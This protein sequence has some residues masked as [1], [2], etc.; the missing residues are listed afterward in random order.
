MSVFIVND[1]KASVQALLFVA[2]SRAKAAQ[3]NLKP[4]EKWSNE[5]SKCLGAEP[6]TQ[7]C[8]TY[9]TRGQGGSDSV[10]EE[11]VLEFHVPSAAGVLHLSLS[12]A[13]PR[14]SAADAKA[15]FPSAEAPPIIDPGSAARAEAFS[16]LE[17]LADNLR[18]LR[19]S[20]FM[21]PAFDTRHDELRGLRR[22]AA[23]KLSGLKRLVSG[24]SAAADMKQ[25]EALCTRLRDLDVDL[26]AS[27]EDPDDDENASLLKRDLAEIEQVMEAAGD[28]ASVAADRTA[29]TAIAPPVNGAGEKKRKKTHNLGKKI[30]NFFASAMQPTAATVGGVLG[31]VFMGPPGAAMG[32]AAGLG[33][34]TGAKNLIRLAQRKSRERKA[35]IAETKMRQRAAA[36]REQFVPE[37]PRPEQLATG[38]SVLAGN[39]DW[40]DRIS[41]L[42]VQSPVG[43]SD[44]DV[45]QA[46]LDDDE[47]ESERLVSPDSNEETHERTP[48]VPRPDDQYGW[49]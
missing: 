37:V 11:M 41:A 18:D 32:S 45:M 25:Y 38:D 40:G 3:V 2:G 8:L 48:Q 36:E 14:T 28:T 34:G 12:K 19:A 47:N 29:A 5:G 35:R 31:F 49:A 15:Q 9:R 27:E 39:N 22:A 46:I 13:N 16:S 1:T 10:E 20:V 21:A 33:L 30:S 6:G 42:G 24:A 26:E 23:L 7:A 4:G 44:G 43:D 17:S